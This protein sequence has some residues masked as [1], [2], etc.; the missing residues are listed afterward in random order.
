[1]LVQATLTPVY[2]VALANPYRV[3]EA[4]MVLVKASSTCITTVPGVV[5]VTK[6]VTAQLSAM[7]LGEP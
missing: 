3:V 6:Q 5:T 7:A 2:P 4:L 1:M